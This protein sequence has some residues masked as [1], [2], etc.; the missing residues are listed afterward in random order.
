MLLRRI[1]TFL[2]TFYF[3]YILVDLVV[4]RVERCEMVFW[5][6]S[7]F[8]NT[9]GISVDDL[10]KLDVWLVVWMVRKSPLSISLQ[11]RFCC[12]MSACMHLT[13]N[14][15]VRILEEKSKAAHLL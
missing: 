8:P 9:L 10:C 2:E 1:H 6:S 13:E 11:F 3:F 15:K 5:L 12:F 7:L 4:V 14:Q